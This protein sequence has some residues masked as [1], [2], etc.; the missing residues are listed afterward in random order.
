MLAPCLAIPRATYRLQF[1]SGFTFADAMAIV[2]YLADLGISHI[3]AS[4]YLKARP[5]SE[6]GYDIIDHNAINPEVGDSESFAALCGALSA[7]GMGQIL[8]FVPNHVGIFGAENKW[9]LDVLT[10]GEDSQYAAY[11]DIDWRPAKPELHG[12]LLVP[13]LGDAYGTILSKGELKLKLDEGSDGFSIWYYENRLPLTPGTFGRILRPAIE[14]LLNGDNPDPARDG[15]LALLAAGF[16]ELSRPARTRP[17]RLSRMA[18]A[19]RLRGD[20][21][22]TLRNHPGL[23]EHLDAVIAEFNGVPGE[24]ASFRRLHQVLEAQHYRLAYWRVAAEEINYR[25]FFQINDLAGIRVEMPEVFDAIHRLVFQWIDEGRVHG[26]RIDHID[27]LFDPRQYLERLQQRFR[28][29]RAETGAE[30]ETARLYVVVE[31]ILAQHESLPADWPIAGT[32]GYDY[33]NTVNALFVNTAAEAQLSRC[34][35]RLIGAL[36]DFHEIAYSG[37]KLAMEQELASELRVLANEINHLTESNWFTRDFTLV[38]LRQALR[39]IVACFPVY[40]TYVDWHGISAEDRRDLDW[41]VAHGRRRSD[42]SDLSVF[43]FLLSLLTTGIGRGRTPALNRREVRRLAMKFQQYTGAVMAKG[44]ED[45]AFYRYNRLISLNEVGGEPTRFG[46]TTGGF[47]RSQQHAARHWPHAMLSTATHDTKRGEDARARINGLSELAGEWTEGV[48]RWSTQNRRHRSDVNDAPAPSEN[49]EYLFYQSLLG[50]WPT[51]LMAD[52]EPDGETMSTLRMRMREFMLKAV[53]EG[54]AHSSW[55]NPDAAYEQA[56]MHFVDRALDASGRNPFID[57]FSAFARRVARIG[58][59]NSLA[60]TT[61]KLT[62]PGVPDVYQG[63]ELWDLSLV[64]PDNRRPVDFGERTEKLRALRQDWRK[65]IDTAW[66]SSLLADWP[67]G[68]V[69]L[70]VTWRL[71]E[72][73]RAE[74][75]LFERGSYRPIATEGER[76]DNLCAFQRTHEQSALLVIVPR[77]VATWTTLPDCWPIG[78]TP[79]QGTDVLMPDGNPGDGWHNVFTGEPLVPVTGRDDGGVRVAAAVLLSTFPVGV[80]IR[81]AAAV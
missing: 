30:G 6:H 69:K 4:P 14:R 56:L 48:Q 55:I 34:Y 40:R 23:R 52:R 9:F 62:S 29:G 64:D 76:A 72:A 32:T 20:L 46:A 39:E 21:A 70:F 41:A 28:Q 58:V 65:G 53:R 7:H 71:L 19:E 44:V 78:P 27:G 74:P 16:D 37:R 66:L 57:S 26:L 73:R 11:F 13:L 8:D 3:Y 18:L 31:K 59:I 75:E 5:G 81:G 25:R 61:L 24:P 50:T 15:R 36:P 35:E 38:G 43:D 12:K 45:T 47:H 17:A 67:S 54:K 63:C 49:D 22:E 10:W 80:W 42:R 33:L 77:L 60:Q 68:R 79:W 1:H 51:E 2:P